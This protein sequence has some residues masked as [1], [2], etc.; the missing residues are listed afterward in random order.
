MWREGV[1]A[2]RFAAEIIDHA[3]E[4]IVV[5]DRDLRYLLW[6]R[7]ME[8]LTGLSADQVLGRHAS[9]IFPHLLEQGIA[10]LLQRAMKGETVAA[11]D[12][13]FNL[14]GGRRRGWVSAVYRPHYDEA[15]Q[16]AGVISLMRDV[17][18][19]KNAEQQIEYQ[20]YHDALTGLA[21]RRLFQEHLGLALA[22]ATRRRGTVAVLFLD[23]D[24]FKVI[25]DTLGH[26][27]GDALLRLIGR[28]LK[29]CVREGDTVARVGGDEFT[30]VL[31]DLAKKED[32]ALVARKVLQSVAE[33]VALNGHRLY[34]TT[35]IGITF[36]P[37]DGEDAE[38]LLRNA[39]NAVYV[40]K[41]EGRNTYQMST[42]EMTRAVQE[43]LML[44]NGLRQA[45]ERGEFVLHYQPQ[46]DLRTMAIVGMEALLRWNHPQRGVLLPEQ[47]IRLAEER[48][49]IVAIGEWVLR[50]AC[51]QA[52]RFCA[53]G[54]PDFRVAVNLSARQLRDHSLVE[55]VAAALRASGLK[56]QCLELEITESVAIENVELTLAVLADLRALGVRIAIDD[57]GT[58]HSSLGYLK[59]FPIDT[60][61]IDK[62]FV[63]DLPDGFEDAAI[64]QAVVQLARGLDLRVIAE[65]VE[66]QQQLDFLQTHACPEV[67]GY[68][69]S[70]PVP[71][72][73]FERMLG[74][75]LSH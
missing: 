5:Y 28:R 32:A 71:A 23:L 35:S 55:S 61:K 7:F 1:D 75:T 15:G 67:Q 36:Y 57:F 50:E 52:A 54:F 70:Y 3:G 49:Y 2:T 53:R 39:D 68:H 38:A 59:R 6:N 22:L 12:L 8:E 64:V 72:V 17:T 48:G 29:S 27:T 4:G 34:V 65:G 25:N 13:H 43:R 45:M 10:A 74:S 46:I 18:E 33:P 16:V 47:F 14:P 66:T 56:P 51:M 26:T 24:N 73:E 9:D 42:A 69:F 62:H 20:A 21:N 19:R 40:A 37:D 30:I 58:G 60:L 44:E 63:E 41:S 11:P 31:Q